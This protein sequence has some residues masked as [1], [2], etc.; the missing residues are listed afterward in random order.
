MHDESK[1]QEI[2]VSLFT[3]A[4]EVSFGAYIYFK[5]Q[6]NSLP[7]QTHLEFVLLSKHVTEVEVKGEFIRD[8]LLGC[9]EH[10][11]RLIPVT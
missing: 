4:L 7:K 11:Y 1:A 6:K 10:I 8:V 5:F 9:H 3:G 2:N